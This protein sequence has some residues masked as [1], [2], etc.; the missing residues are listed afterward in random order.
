DSGARAAYARASRQRPGIAAMTDIRGI[1]F[2]KDGTLID[3]TA[4]WYAAA[5]AMALVA[6]AGERARA[7][8]LL[9][10]AGYD[11]SARRFRPDSVLAAGTN[12]D[13]I[14]LW[15]PREA[16]AER[17]AMLEKFE[18]MIGSGDL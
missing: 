8:A 1:L 7:D 17:R 13:L 2:D 14:A 12:A 6:A 11:F 9:D 16:E 4:T 10:A 18:R 3:F 15:Y 5:D